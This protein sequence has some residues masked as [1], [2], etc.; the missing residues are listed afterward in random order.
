MFIY[1]LVDEVILTRR[2]WEDDEN[3]NENENGMQVFDGLECR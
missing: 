1:I 2:P 3:E